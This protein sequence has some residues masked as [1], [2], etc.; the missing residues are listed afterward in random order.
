M[1]TTKKNIAFSKK[2]Q[3]LSGAIED[4]FKQV[5]ESLIAETKKANGYLVMA[6]EDGRVK[7][8]PAK[9]L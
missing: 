3:A 4:G 2:H 5:S 7:K 1:G 9:D 6:D 8:V